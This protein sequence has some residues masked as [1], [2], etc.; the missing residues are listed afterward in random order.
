MNK[1]D[2]FLNW[3]VVLFIIFG[4]YNIEKIDYIKKLLEK[5]AVYGKIIVIKHFWR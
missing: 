4:E 5:K 3:K 2:C 1:K